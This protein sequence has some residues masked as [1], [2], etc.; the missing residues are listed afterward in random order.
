MTL[1][2]ESARRAGALRELLRSL[3]AD[4]GLFA[5]RERMLQLLLE[6]R[7]DDDSTKR[8]LRRVTLQR[9]RAQADLRAVR[10]A[11]EPLDVRLAEVVEVKEAG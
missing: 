4:L 9:R 2:S 3:R 11:I 1:R 10:A 6:N 7:S 8:S 5:Q